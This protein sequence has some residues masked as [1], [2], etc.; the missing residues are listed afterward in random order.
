MFS[1]LRRSALLCD[2]TER[3]Y[4]VRKVNS[5]PLYSS[6]NRAKVRTLA[7]VKQV[8]SCWIQGA[9]DTVQFLGSV[10]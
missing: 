9:A 3:N 10:L 5:I 4:N 2:E 7:D 8:Q 1:V 6:A